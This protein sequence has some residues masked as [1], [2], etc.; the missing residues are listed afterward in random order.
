MQ[1]CDCRNH[2]EPPASGRT[3]CPFR[4]DLDWTKDSKPDYVVE[5]FPCPEV[6]HGFEKREKRAK[7]E[8]DG[9]NS[10]LQDAGTSHHFI[11]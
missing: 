4:Q 2:T 8:D 6:K 11:E 7:N 1:S 5:T 3:A 10:H 9:E